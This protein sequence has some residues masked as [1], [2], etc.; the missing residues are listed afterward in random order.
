M[1]T[2]AIG[3]STCFITKMYGVKRCS[4]RQTG[5]SKALTHLGVLFTM[6]LV[7][8]RRTD[9]VYKVVARTGLVLFLGFLVAIPLPL[10]AQSDSPADNSDQVKSSDKKDK[11]KEKEKDKDK[12]NSKK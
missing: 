9:M 12:E 6:I 11:D 2:G 7:C 10:L 3:T 5:P 8:L 1:P 4:E